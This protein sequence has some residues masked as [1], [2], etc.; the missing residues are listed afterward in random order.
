MLW[1]LLS[2]NAETGG[3]PVTGYKIFSDD[4]AGGSFSLIATISNGNQ[5]TYIHSPVTQGLSYQYKILA[6][7]I[8]GDG[9]ESTTPVVII[10]TG[11][12]DAPAAPT[13]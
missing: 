8:H 6:F 2:T 13:V 3:S 7:N 1:N 11:P 12:P 10:P 5:Q 9:A 4:A